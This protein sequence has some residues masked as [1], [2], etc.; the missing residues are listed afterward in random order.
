MTDTDAWIVAYHELERDY[1]RLDHAW[2]QKYRELELEYH[3]THAELLEH[4]AK[5]AE[6]ELDPFA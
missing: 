3:R 1:A 5:A 2:K 6:A 4:V